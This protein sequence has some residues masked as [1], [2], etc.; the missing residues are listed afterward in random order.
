MPLTETL[1]VVLLALPFALADAL[2]DFNNL[3]T[4]CTMMSN[5]LFNSVTTVNNTN[6][7]PGVTVTSPYVCY[8]L[9]KRGTTMYARLT[10]RKGHSWRTNQAH[11][12][13]WGFPVKLR[14]G[15]GEAGYTLISVL[16]T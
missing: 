11:L 13:C 14:E 16:H 6:G 3:Y 10:T 1:L 2:T 15:H 12:Y 8:G 4:R 9:P 5:D 7:Q